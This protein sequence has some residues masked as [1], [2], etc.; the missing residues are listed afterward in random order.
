ML[1]VDTP[2]GVFAHEVVAEALT[3]SLLQV[4]PP[5]VPIPLPILSR[6]PLL[7]SQNLPIVPR[8]PTAPPPPPRSIHRSVGP[9]RFGDCEGVHFLNDFDPSSASLKCLFAF[10][11][12]AVA[13]YLDISRR[14][15]PA[16]AFHPPAGTLLRV[17]DIL[18][19]AVVEVGGFLWYHFSLKG[20]EMSVLTTAVV[21]QEPSPSPVTVLV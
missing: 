3:R 9:L 11:W 7:H 5:L 4:P 6:P 20:S 2:V 19:R 10:C 1:V 21:L 17:A 13:G 15:Y 16:A 8:F 12:V 14:G 18:L